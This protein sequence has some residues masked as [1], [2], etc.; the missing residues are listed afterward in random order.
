MSKTPTISKCRNNLID[1]L[2]ILKFVKELLD[3][4]I[5]SVALSEGATIGLTTILSRIHERGWEIAGDM[6]AVERIANMAKA[7]KGGEN[8]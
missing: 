5:D 8:E 3:Q 1:E 7:E 6:E 2:N 4:N